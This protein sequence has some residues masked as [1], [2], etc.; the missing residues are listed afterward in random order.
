[1]RR[2]KGQAAAVQRVLLFKFD[3]VPS[4]RWNLGT[5]SQ[6]TGTGDGGIHLGHATEWLDHMNK[7]TTTNKTVK[8][9]PCVSKAP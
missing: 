9:L 3:A 2:F 1:M 5:V 4:R 8:H 7:G 6:P